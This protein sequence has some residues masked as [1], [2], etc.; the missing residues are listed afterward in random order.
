MSER[1]LH[2]GLE[3]PAVLSIWRPRDRADEQFV[4]V[5]DYANGYVTIERLRTKTL[6]L[7]RFH[8]EYEFDRAQA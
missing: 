7:K 1:T 2:E 6:S 3:I 8:R 4:K 5:L